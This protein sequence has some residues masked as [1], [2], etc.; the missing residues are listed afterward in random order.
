MEGAVL[1]WQKQ[2]VEGGYFHLVINV[3]MSTKAESDTTF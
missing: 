2:G 1:K 3:Q